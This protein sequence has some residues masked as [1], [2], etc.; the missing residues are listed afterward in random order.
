MLDFLAHFFALSNPLW[1]LWPLVLVIG[2][3]YKTTQY[4][5]PKDILKGTLHFVGSVAGFMLLL[6]IVL[7]AVAVWF[8]GE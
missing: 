5:K 7:Y 1:Y 2:A 8:G 4:D 3:V 6:A